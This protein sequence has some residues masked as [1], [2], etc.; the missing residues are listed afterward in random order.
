MKHQEST[1]ISAE[2]ISETVIMLPPDEQEKGETVAAVPPENEQAP[3]E[4]Q[5]S[6]VGDDRITQ[7]P[8]VTAEP[9]SMGGD[10]RNSIL[11]A[12]KKPEQ[13]AQLLQTQVDQLS[14]PVY[15]RPPDGAFWRVR[16]CADWNPEASEFLMLPRKDGGSG[17]EFMLV[18]PELEPLFNA[19]PRLRN[20]VRYY[21]LA[22]VVDVR[23]RVGW[24]A[25]PSRSENEWHVSARTAMRRLQDEWSMIKADQGAKSY[26]LERPM[27]EIGDPVW[28]SG[29]CEE[30]LVK[31]LGDKLLNSESH[32]LVR[33]L[34]GQN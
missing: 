18:A 32:E 1:A 24:W 30:W 20:L 34:R 7:A 27:D 33:Q 6:I 12:R 21:Y 16:S 28:P 23:G 5:G 14:V 4:N 11:A 13:V 29:S 15:K 10:V 9:S 3:V 8:V 25:V 22:F 2:S 31:G 17:P 19:D 26:N